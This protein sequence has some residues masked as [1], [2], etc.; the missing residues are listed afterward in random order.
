MPI[1]SVCEYRCLY[2]VIVLVYL[3][4][5]RFYLSCVETLSSGLVLGSLYGFCF[6]FPLE[7]VFGLDE[8]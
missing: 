7:K 8:V 2:E 1:E 6:S 5:G 3:S 4:I